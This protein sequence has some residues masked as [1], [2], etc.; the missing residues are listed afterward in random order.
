MALI[1][2]NVFTAATA[3]T[4]TL[5]HSKTNYTGHKALAA[6]PPG[7]MGTKARRPSAHSGRTE[8]IVADTGG[9]WSLGP[10]FPLHT[11]TCVKECLRHPVV[12]QQ[13]EGSPSAGP[14][15]RGTKRM[16]FET[17]LGGV[18]GAFQ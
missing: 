9:R 1:S 5:T 3:H 17:S 10:F 7:L 12:G 2:P 8:P 15:V 4:H 18:G 13:G 14:G 6:P 11:A 16:A